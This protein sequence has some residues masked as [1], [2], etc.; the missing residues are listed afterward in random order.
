[1]LL[2]DRATWLRLSA[3]IRTCGLKKELMMDRSQVHVNPFIRHWKHNRHNTRRQ[4][5]SE[6]SPAAGWPL[7]MQIA[8]VTCAVLS[9]HLQSEATVCRWL[10]LPAQSCRLQVSAPAGIQLG[11]TCCQWL[12][13]FTLPL[14][15]RYVTNHL[16]LN[17]LLLLKLLAG[18]WVDCK[19][20]YASSNSSITRLH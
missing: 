4:K 18:P 13:C 20:Q 3:V 5:T 7:R 19:S 2:V 16:P 11:S 8:M 9:P 17:R 15:P 10:Q 14:Y 1:M 6:W 12:V